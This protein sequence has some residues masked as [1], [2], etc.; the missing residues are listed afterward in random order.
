MKVDQLMKKYNKRELALKFLIE[1]AL[2]KKYK[3]E[4]DQ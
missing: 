3:K 1:E 4:G 2:V